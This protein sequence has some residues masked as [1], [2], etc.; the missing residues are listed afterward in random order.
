MFDS[1]IS[2]LVLWVIT[3]RNVPLNQPQ[4]RSLVRWVWGGTPEPLCSGFLFSLLHFRNLKGVRCYFGLHQ[5]KRVWNRPVKLDKFRW[6]RHK[7]THTTVGRTLMCENFI[8]PIWHVRSLPVFHL[9]KV[10]IHFLKYHV[11]PHRETHLTL[12]VLCAFYL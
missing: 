11:I 10:S 3:Q 6:V 7:M 12:S 5:T 9:W 2:S 8:F 4:T 1:L